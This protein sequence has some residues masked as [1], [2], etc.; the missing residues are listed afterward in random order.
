MYPKPPWS[1]RKMNVGVEDFQVFQSGIP[2]GLSNSLLSFATLHFTKGQRVKTVR[3]LRV[4]SLER[5]TDRSLP[6]HPDALLSDFSVDGDLLLDA[7]DHVLSYPDSDIQEPSVA[8][9]ILKFYFYEARSELD[10]IHVQDNEYQLGYR[11]PPEVTEIVREATSNRSRA[12]EHLQRAWSFGFSREAKPNS[13]CHEAIN[14][15]EAAAKGII[16]PNNSKAT[17]GTMIS[18]IKSNPTKWQTDLGEP[19]TNDVGT[20]LGMMTMIWKG[21]LRHGNPDDPLDV[22][23]ER[24]EMVVHTAAILVHWFQSGRIRLASS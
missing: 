19:D 15:V 9:G 11:Q 2:D 1:I 5:I 6:R 12:S 8:A 17:L 18:A 14:A 21:H 10:V 4:E 7:I 24:C 16:E 23:V 22:S 20:I 3:V 13:A